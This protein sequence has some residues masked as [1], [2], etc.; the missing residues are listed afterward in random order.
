MSLTRF[1]SNVIAK[2]V[3]CYLLK[4]DNELSFVLMKSPCSKKSL[5]SVS[6]SDVFTV[7]IRRMDSTSWVAIRP[8]KH[9]VAK[10]DLFATYEGTT[11]FGLSSPPYPNLQL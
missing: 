3:Q 6:G 1:K 2:F 9:E 10:C 4:C 11:S 7:G 5:G 8:L